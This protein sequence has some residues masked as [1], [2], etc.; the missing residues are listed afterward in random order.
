MGI[1]YNVK[2]YVYDKSKE[3]TTVSD[4]IVAI[5][6]VDGKFDL[7]WDDWSSGYKL[8][9]MKF[10]SEN[11]VFDYLRTTFKH[12]NAKLVIINKQNGK[13]TTIEG[14]EFKSKNNGKLY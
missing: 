3:C 6:K 2:M 10:N 12:S 4:S 7:C 5:A 1:L 11:D 14:T 8:S 13:I 9:G